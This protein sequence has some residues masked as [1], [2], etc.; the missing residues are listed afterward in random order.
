MEEKRLTL[1]DIGVTGAS[2]TEAAAT[3]PAVGDASAPAKKDA[4]GSGIGM[5]ARS[6]DAKAVDEHIKTSLRNNVYNHELACIIV[7]LVSPGH[8]LDRMGGAGLEKLTPM[9]HLIIACV[10]ITGTVLITNP[11][12]R[13]KVQGSLFGGKT[14]GRRVKDARL[15][16]PNRPAKVHKAP[17]D[18]DPPQASGGTDPTGL[19]LQTY[20]DITGE[21][22]TP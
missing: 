18:P 10:A 11:D 16:D 8:A 20:M 4:E 12:L 7:D 5:S 1:D 2:P 6:A 22:L 17:R 3:T 19:P 14:D 15:P 21:P 13:R 9:Q